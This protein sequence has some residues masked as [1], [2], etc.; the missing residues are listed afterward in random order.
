MGGTNKLGERS[1]TVK[2]SKKMAAQISW[3]NEVRQLSI[4]DPSKSRMRQRNSW[5]FLRGIHDRATSECISSG[6]SLPNEPAGIFATHRCYRCRGTDGFLQSNQFCSLCEE[7]RRQ[8]AGQ[9]RSCCQ[10]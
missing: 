5:L 3:A 8:T 10:H 6:W 2:H 1:A 7:P 9:P 4:T